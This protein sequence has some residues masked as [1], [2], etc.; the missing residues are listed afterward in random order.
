MRLPLPGRGDA[1][2]WLL[3]SALQGVGEVKGRAPW[4]AWFEIIFGNLEQTRD[5]HFVL[6]FPFRSTGHL[7][8]N[9]PFGQFLRLRRNCS[10]ILDYKKQAKNLALKL[11]DDVLFISGQDQQQRGSQEEHSQESNQDQGYLH[12]EVLDLPLSVV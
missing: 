1:S 2:L 4:V 11:E 8:E 6:T 12:T 7:K 3:E 5:M 9:L 10:E